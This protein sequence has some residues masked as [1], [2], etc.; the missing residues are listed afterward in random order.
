MRE[1]AN[2]Q[3]RRML[4]WIAKKPEAGFSLIEM[5]V[6][7]I[8]LVTLAVILVPGWRMFLA[9]RDLQAGQDQ[10]LQAMMEAQSSAKSNRVMW[11]LSLRQQG[12]QVQ[13]VVHPT[14]RAPLTGEWQ[15][16][17]QYIRIDSETSVPVSSGV[18]TVQFNS[19]G[20]VNNLGSIALNHTQADS[21]T[22]RCVVISTL[23]G[24]LRSSSNQ[25]TTQNGQWCY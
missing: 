18:Y 1:T 11:Q 17:S 12:Q 25:A 4:E 6:V 22:K 20:S 5:L 2:W 16:L 15:R 14:Y 3:K 24:N 19:D 10:L 23:I 9:S 21:R 7:M 8:I 13:W